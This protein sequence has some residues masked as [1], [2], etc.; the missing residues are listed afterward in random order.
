VTATV[1]PRVCPICGSSGGSI[2]FRQR[3]AGA[4]SGALLDGYDVVVCQDCGL[5][6]ADGV[7]PQPVLDEY[8]ASMSKYEHTQEDGREGSFAEQRFP[9]AAAFIRS[10][11]DDTHIRILDV[12]CSNGGLLHALAEQGFNNLL[13]M[14]PSP[15]C[16]RTAERLYGM[17]VL[18]GTLSSPPPETAGSE[19]VLLSA[20]LEHVR[21]LGGALA[22]VR[23]LLAPYGFLY[24]EVP[25]VTRFG[26]S[27]DAPFQEF[28][29]EHINYF[30]RTSLRNLL[31]A[32]GFA[33]VTSSTVATIQ[34]EHSTA[35]VIMAVF[36]L[37]GADPG[38]LRRD[39]E[40]PRALAAYVAACSAEEDQLH[41]AL[42]PL[43]AD[44]R[45]LIV[46]GVGTHTQR[47]L[48]ESPLGRANITAFV[49]SNP[50]YHGKRL[51]GLPVLSPAE[52]AGR[53]EAILI[54][55]RFYQAEIERQIR[56]D[57]DL[58][59]EIVV[60]YAL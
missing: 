49:D 56:Q 2:I 27:P 12:G 26:A 59:N 17:R 1:E 11:V 13:G 33:E 16:A 7:P 23:A 4:L 44:G 34:G 53:S 39:D 3:F 41:A 46:W 31:D 21:D 52:L 32:A 37:T 58:T 51:A 14:D 20:V 25:D 6:Y 22:Q 43:A 10:V 50:V 38:P 9:G 8:Y 15:A 29:V 30:S 42:D 60:L 24:V 36:R 55:S 18:T 40:T 54:S 48:A 28:S 57:L 47:L 19:L 35:H 45:P 5:G